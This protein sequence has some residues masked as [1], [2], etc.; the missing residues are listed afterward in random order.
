M[1]F[2]SLICIISYIFKG[3]NLAFYIHRIPILIV[4]TTIITLFI[5]Q[6]WTHLIPTTFSP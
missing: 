3:M 6:M 1:H 2:R 5:C 4:S